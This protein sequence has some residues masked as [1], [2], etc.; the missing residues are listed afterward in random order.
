MQTWNL[1]CT[2]ILVLNSHKQCFIAAFS[3][4]SFIY[5][6]DVLENV[7]SLLR[8]WLGRNVVAS[9]LTSSCPVDRRVHM[10]VP[11]CVE[12]RKKTQTWFGTVAGTLS[13]WCP[14][15]FVSGMKELK[16]PGWWKLADPSPPTMDLCQSCL[17]IDYCN[18]V[19][20]LTLLTLPT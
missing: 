2:N 16:Q 15:Y 10:K 18:V 17:L 1:M 4:F 13:S 3:G 8:C 19:K 12:L 6:M 9:F 7:K 5:W 11:V 20:I 14:M